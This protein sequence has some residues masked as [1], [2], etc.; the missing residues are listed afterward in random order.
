MAEKYFDKAL[1]TMPPGQRRKYELRE[2]RRMFRHAYAHCEGVKKQFDR[3]KVKPEQLKTLKDLEKI[4]VLGK[5]ELRMLQEQLPPFGGYLGAPLA[6]LKSIFYSP[7]PMFEP[8]E[9]SEAFLTRHARVFYNAGL[10]KGDILLST[11]SYH[12]VPAG[13]LVHESA[14]KVGATAIPTGPGN[15]ELQ[16]D[17]M[18][19]LG[20]TA[21][22]GTPSFLAALIER[23]EEKGY[24]FQRDFKLRKALCSVEVLTPAMRS[25]LQS[26]G[27]NVS[28]GYAC[29]DIGNFAYECGRKN[30]FHIC[31]EVFVEIVD[32]VTRKKLGPGEVGEVVVTPLD[33]RVYPLVRFGIGD[34]SQYT[35]E[36]C[37]CGRTSIR[38]QGFMGRVGEA[39]KV[40]GMFL[41]P[42]Q[43]GDFLSD[44]T[45]VSGWSAVVTRARQRDELA[46]RVVLSAGTSS[47]EQLTNR[48][49]SKFA[50][51]CRVKLDRVECV[52]GEAIPDQEAAKVIDRRE[53]K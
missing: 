43:V 20:V 29:A 30:G 26:Y 50:E 35:D 48:I 37:A 40:R 31:E 39:V 7:G 41:H 32:P 44:F 15:T 52:A 12:M 17:I 13:L 14:N 11:F 3:A 5:D 22:I 53:W 28:Q 38:M 10:R 24:V 23:A 51:I 47:T 6:S 46:L 42:R 9:T 19:T 8:H 2:L 49:S 27:I 21:Y 45:E 16:L 4:P 1:E 36:T 34:L 33:A 25:H 18:R